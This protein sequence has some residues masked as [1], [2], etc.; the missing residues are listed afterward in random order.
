MC[1]N[2]KAV[3]SPV[4][5]FFHV[6]FQRLLLFFSFAVLST[7][8]YSQ[9]TY[10]TV[11]GVTGTTSGPIYSSVTAAILGNPGQG[12]GAA[13]VIEVNGM[14]SPSQPIPYSQ[15]HAQSIG[16]M[17][18]SFPIDLPPY[19]FVRGVSGPVLFAST[20]GASVEL[21]RMPSNITTAYVGGLRNIQLWGADIGIVLGN[22]TSNP[23]DFTLEECSFA[24]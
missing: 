7:S 24:N 11:D 17:S 20:T 14:G 5:H 8:A 1:L 16:Q 2:Q 4:I 22:S 23:V 9:A 6:M 15:N 10:V 13:L 19:T 18:E 12:P 3:S 21:F